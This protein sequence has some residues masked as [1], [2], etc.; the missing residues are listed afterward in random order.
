M[1]ATR[2]TE[3]QLIE[4]LMKSPT[5]RVWPLC[6]VVRCFWPPI[7]LGQYRAKIDDSG[8]L[9]W[10][11]TWGFFSP[12]VGDGLIYGDRQLTPADWQSGDDLWFLDVIAPY[13]HAREVIHEMETLFPGRVAYSRRTRNGIRH[14]HVWFGRVPKQAAA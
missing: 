2:I 5:H 14:R 3:G 8:K 10:L 4:L 7:K 12:E 13:G 1:G 9:L 6:G 11:A